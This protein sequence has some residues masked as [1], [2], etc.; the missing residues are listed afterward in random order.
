MSSQHHG[1]DVDRTGQEAMTIEVGA[2]GNGGALA[3]GP[4]AVQV[5]PGTTVVREWTGEG[6]QHNVVVRDEGAD[7]ESP[8][9]NEA[10]AIVVGPFVAGELLATPCSRN[11]PVEG[12]YPVFGRV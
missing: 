10:G 11:A 1:I 5:D 2:E 3:F 7:A 4:A 9:Q 8:L 6:G 12:H